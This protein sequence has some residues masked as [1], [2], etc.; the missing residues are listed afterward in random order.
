MYPTTGTRNP[1]SVSDCV[2]SWNYRTPGTGS[3]RH[4]TG[5]RHGNGNLDGTDTG[6]PGLQSQDEPKNLEPR[7]RGRAQTD[8][9]RPLDDTIWRTEGYGRPP[10][11]GDL[12]ERGVEGDDD[13]GVA[14]L[15]S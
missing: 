7:I 5:S 8:S 15:P 1:E 14:E 9:D 4:G 6:L 3:Q 12:G 2:T 11:P 10:R 13:D